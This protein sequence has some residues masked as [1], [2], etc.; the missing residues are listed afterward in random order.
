[1]QKHVLYRVSSNY[2]HGKPKLFEAEL[3]IILQI[4]SL[5]KVYLDPDTK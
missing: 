5:Q 2:A 4:Y 1:M 3:S